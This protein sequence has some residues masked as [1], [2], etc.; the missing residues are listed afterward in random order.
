MNYFIN[1]PSTPRLANPV[2]SVVVPRVRVPSEPRVPRVPV[3]VVIP[4]V[5]VVPVVV[6]PVLRMRNGST[7]V[8]ARI[9]RTGQTWS[10]R[11]SILAGVGVGWGKGRQGHT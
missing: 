1:L 6:P 5:V 8:T 4:V 2:P 10:G 9:S 11:S 3:D 7:D